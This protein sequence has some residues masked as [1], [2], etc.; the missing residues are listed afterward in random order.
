MSEEITKDP[1]KACFLSAGCEQQNLELAAYAIGIE[2]EWLDGHPFGKCM[3]RVTGES[4]P[5]AARI[6]WRPYS[7]SNDALNLMA[8]LRMEVSWTS[9]NM[10]VVHMNVA[11]HHQVVS[12]TR[13][14]SHPRNRF[15]DSPEKAIRWAVV[16]AAAEYGRKLKEI[17]Y[18]P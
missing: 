14:Y 13:E 8:R 7:D 11:Y 10:V 18:R 2:V 12:V 9:R 3:F 15:A 4:F 1:D 17:G 16:Q 5:N 6:P